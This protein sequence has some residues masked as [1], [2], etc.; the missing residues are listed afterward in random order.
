MNQKLSHRLWALSVCLILLLSACTFGEKAP[1]AKSSDND[2]LTWGR[3]GSGY[4]DFLELATQTY[5][6]IKWELTAYAGTNS[7]GYSWVQMRADDIPDIFI[8]TKVVDADLAKERLVDL[9]YY[10]FIDGLPTSLL[11]RVSIDGGIYLL[12]VSNTISGI[13]YNKTLMEER[14]WEVPTNFA[15][16]EALCAE[17]EEAGLIPGVITTQLTGASFS[18]VF[19]LAKTSWFTTLDGVRWEQDFLAGNATAAGTWEDTMDYVQRYIDIGMFYTDPEDRGDADVMKDYLGNRKA[20][21][22][23]AIAAVGYTEFDNG[24]ELGMMPLISE[25]GSKNIYMYTP[26]TYIGISRKL[27]EPGNEEKLENAVKMLAL[28]FSPEGQ[29]TCITEQTPCVLSVLG[30]DAVSEDSMIYDA[31]QA[32]WDGRAFPITYEHWEDVLSDMGQAYKE[33]I[34]GENGMDGPGCIA[35]MDELQST[36]LNN[37]DSLYFCESTADFTLEETAL[38]I[39]KAV[40]STVGADAVLIATCQD[41]SLPE[42]RL[43]VTGKLYEG[44]I[45]AEILNTILYGFA[46]GTNGEYAIMT[47]TGLQVK[48]LAE[49]GFDKEGN[50]NVYPYILVTRGG[51]SLEDDEI[52][53]IAFTANSYTEEVG[54]IY[55]VQVVKAEDFL[56]STVRVWMEEQGRVSPDGNPWE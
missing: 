39:G 52:Y 55:N 37:S 53:Q 27:T 6:E 25:D 29:A 48:E 30:N 41:G 2:V 42:L 14:G 32:M 17:I 36:Y 40:G 5:P 23:T 46:Y 35:R 51:V 12:P 33:W 43:G 22:C 3:W 10:D 54:Q 26:S 9:S 44:P 8:T 28:L 49:T 45:N 7:T 4:G 13:Y 47:M 34:R 24:D 56:R 19:N 31:Q 16:L 11:D 1:D 50:G 18:T 21:F 20:V 15:E 38:L